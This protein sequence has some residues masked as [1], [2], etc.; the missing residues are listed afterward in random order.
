VP[1]HADLVCLSQLVETGQLLPHVDRVYPLDDTAAALRHIEG[2][3]A[4][5]KIVV[6]L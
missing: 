4:R 3:H 5:G 6:A 1:S 2:G